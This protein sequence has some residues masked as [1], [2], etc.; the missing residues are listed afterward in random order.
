MYMGENRHNMEN[1]FIKFQDYLKRLRKMYFEALCAFCVFEAVEELKAPNISGGNEAEKNVAIVNKFKNFFI[2][3]RRTLNFYFLME[4]AK[5]LDTAKQS[6]HLTKLI[7]FASNNKKL[8]VKEFTKLNSDRAFL[9]DL[10]KRYEGI[11]KEDFEKIERNLEETKTIREKIKLYRDQN[12]AH[13]DINKEDVD[14]SQ[15]EIVK[16]FDLIAEILDIFSSKTDFSTTDYTAII[17]GCKEDT[18][19]VIE[20]LKRFEPYRLKEIN[21]KYESG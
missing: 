12:L 6:L 13:E 14:I 4:I 5:I 2:P 18:K 3:V 16:I 9:E 19:N 15:E 1:E 11:K 20:Y 7:N 8:G 21:D 10:A 17:K